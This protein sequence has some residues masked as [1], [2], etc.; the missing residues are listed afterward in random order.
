MR[1]VGSNRVVSAETADFIKNAMRLAVTEGTAKVLK[2]NPAR[3]A[4]KTEKKA[5][6]WYLPQPSAKTF[7]NTSRC[8]L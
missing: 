5:E 2:D 6:A 8:L 1:E 3:I 7:T 4:G